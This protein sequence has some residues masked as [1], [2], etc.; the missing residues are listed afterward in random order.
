[1]TKAAKPSGGVRVDSRLAPGS[2]ATAAARHSRNQRSH[3]QKSCDVSK[4]APA[5]LARAFNSGILP[6]MIDSVRQSIRKLGVQPNQHQSRQ[7]SWQNIKTDQREIYK[8]K[9]SI[10]SQNSSHRSSMKS[11]QSTSKNNN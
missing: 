7:Q 10:L 4:E 6:D 1:M 2:N 5:A 11:L 3:T 9:P 8:L